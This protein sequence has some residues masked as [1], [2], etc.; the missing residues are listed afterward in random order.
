MINH[1]KTKIPIKSILLS[2][3]FLLS[4]GGESSKRALDKKDMT[5]LAVML[6]LLKKD[7]NRQNQ[8]HGNQLN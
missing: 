3:F 6:N 5:V 1:V 2:L 7:D 4:C 8:Q